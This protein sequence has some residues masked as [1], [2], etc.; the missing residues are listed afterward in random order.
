MPT[1]AS[2]LRSTARRVPDTVAL[3]F[4]ERRCTY[5]ELDARVDRTA[6]AA[7]SGWERASASGDHPPTALTRRGGTVGSSTS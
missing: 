7:T 4:G 2:T 5:R 1:I 6:T 3:I